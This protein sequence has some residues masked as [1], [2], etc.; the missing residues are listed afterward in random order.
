MVPTPKELIL[1]RSNMPKMKLRS[2]S[3]VLAFAATLV[4]FA[5][6]SSQKAAVQLSATVQVSPPVINLSWTTMASTTSIAI[7][8]KLKTATSWGSIIATP[9]TAALTWTDNTVSVGTAYE[10]K[11]V[12]VAGGV[13]GSGYIASGIEIPVVDY[14]GKMI[15]LVDNMLTGNLVPELDQ[16]ILDLRGDG[17]TVLRS[18]LSPTASVTSVRNTIIGYYNADPANVKAVYIVGNINVPY[19]GNVNPDGHSEHLGAW[20]CDGYYGELN[21]TWTDNTVNSTAAN[22]VENRNVPGDGK[23]DQSNF[24]SDLELQVGRV[25]LSDL[26]AFSNTYT[27]LTRSY[28][29]RAHDFK[30]KAWAPQVRGIMFD[31]LQWI[32]DPLA[33]SG[34]RAMAPLVGPANIT[35]PNQNSTPFHLLVNNNSYMWAYGSG[36]GVA[37]V[38]QGI[39]TFNGAT[40]IATTQDFAVESPGCVFGMSFGSYFG[41]WDN[42]NNFLRAWI[43]RGQALTNVWSAIPGWYM[44]HMGL[45]DNIGYSTWITMNNSS[46]YTPLEDGWQSSIGRTHLGLM[47]D[48]SIRM[49]ML[50]PPSNI[51]ITNSSGIASFAWTAT[52]ETGIAG[53]HVYQFDAGTGAI[54]R[55][56]ATPVSG[57]SY[58][59]PAIP[60]VAGR[61]YMVR[62]V[63]LEVSPSGSYWNQSLGAIGT[64]AGA[65]SND[66][67][68]VPGGSALP[69]TACNDNNACTIND[70]WSAG[71]V[72]V[73]TTIT[74][75]VITNVGGGGTIC[76]GQNISLTVA[77]TGQGT[78]SFAWTGPNGFTSSSQ[79]PTLSSAGTAA[80]GT[81]TV[82]VSNAC[83]SVNQ[84]VPVSVSTAPS[85]TISYA[86]S[87]FCTSASP[88]NVTRTG[89]ANGT[90]TASPSG[91][92]INS[93][94]GAITPGSST[95]GTYTVTYT[96]AAAGGCAQ[97]QTTAS[98]TITAA[99]SAMI[100]Y[101]GSPFCTSASP[102][103]VTRT[104]T[105]NGTYTASP[106]GLSI[107]S[108]SGAIT[109][110]SS[111]AGTY[112]VT[113]TVAAA[114][115]CAQFQTTASVT[116]TAATTWYADTDGD[117]AGD[118]AVSLVACA[119]PGGYVAS[120]GDACPS[121]P[122][123]TNPG[124][125]GCGNPEPGTSCNDG[126]ANTIGDV[127][128]ANCTCAGTPI[129]FD[130]LGVAN[131]TALPGTACNDGNA[132]TG[133][134]T[135]N[136]N[137]QCV[138]Q[139]IDCLG[140]AGG[141]ALPGTACNDNNANTINDVWGNNCTCAGTPVT[142][143]CLGVANGTA[144]PGTAC[145]DNNANTGNDT[146][147]ASC[148][149]V[150]QTMDCLG[151]AGGSALP[152]TA[153]NDNNANTINDV[154][155]NNCTC[156]G[157]LVTFDCLGVA[158]GT[159]LPGTT[160]NDGNATTGND[161]WNANC[162]C[163]G[164]TI[165]CLGVANG[166]ALPGTAC[167][168]N[169]ANTGNDTWNANCQCVGQTFDC[170]G[171]AGGTALPGTACNDN[172]A[173]TIND[174]W[175]N[176]CTCAGTPVTFDCLGVANGTALPGTACNDNNA[177][178]GN[179]TWNANCQ[180]V[181]Q[182]I[183][184]LGV[185][186]GSALPATACNDNNANTI[187]D[188]WGN[189]CTC[190][191]TPVTFDCL[192]VA[193]GTAL[194][195]TACNDNNANTINDVWGNNCT[196]AGTP[197]TFDCLGVA[198]GTALPGTA[199]NDNNATTGN[200]TW[201]A[202]CQCVGQT[203][204]CLGV[205][206]GS[207]LPGS[208]C[209]DNN[210]NTIND[211]WGNNCT[212]AGTPVTFDCLGVAN[213][214]ALPGTACNDGN[215]FT[216]TDQWNP[217]C[218]CVGTLDIADCAGVPGGSATI[219]ACG[220]C[221][222]GTTGLIPDADTDSD[223]LLDC[224]DNCP[225]V[226]NNAQMDY[227]GDGV[228]DACDNCVWQ[229]NPDQ[230]DSD[231]NGQGDVCDVTTGIPEGENEAVFRLSPN[232]SR[233]GSLNVECT[234]AGRRTLRFH[235][236][237]GELVLESGFQQRME[238]D[239]LATGVYIVFAIDAE[240]RP[241]AQTRFVK[242]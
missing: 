30:R 4:S 164:Q 36:G 221:A 204:D 51:A 209:D 66:C 197:V 222:G 233:G 206:G 185:A 13:T 121:D 200:D 116:I 9:S 96:V 39:N 174:V 220:V 216:T 207:A 46:L 82:T 29:N 88:V 99:A 113:Y 168:D 11:V 134:D 230:L 229:F 87:P 183:D 239:A 16:L 223:G 146:W 65:A 74:A 119:Q 199:C 112:T 86:G 201:N 132:N 124:S 192:G 6:T 58:L 137:C 25:D 55:L 194:P 202:N 21:G 100:S 73:G 34:W 71:C 188:V 8:R 153:C 19:S 103:S 196:C 129:I 139:T 79:N 117:G 226:A 38:D 94:S 15:L 237:V 105:A 151:V 83:G 165:D 106:S 189:N 198:N 191:G 162:Q 234:Y 3:I 148:Q 92:S 22:R 14:R 214:T 18:D 101:A 217:D 95:A 125:C 115:G 123:K 5:Q 145:N 205:A 110:G 160:C 107:N 158:N 177:T 33:A 141:T 70:T 181:G 31:N 231:G 142:F 68:G 173:N 7:Y 144:L 195:G 210:A 78:L 28:L 166:T 186:G 20:P 47:G 84:G 122:L 49:K 208:A 159:A 242:Q 75:P 180:C 171:V 240:G 40:N 27:E 203:I 61:D 187:N 143:D 127:I 44:H 155:G 167:N 1:G 35:A 104:G 97:F 238:I 176:N 69:G 42:R 157:T 43:A 241:L 26:P 63:K 175:G 219:D 152:A 156:A 76:A 150:G 228:G 232:P 54:T 48:P 212:C 102:V 67:L 32:S 111:I 60:F 126:N 37:A 24:P 179:D 114:G 2:L 10:Y 172:N 12:R 178:T 118:P 131:G 161:T 163:V 59:N 225:A 81:Y 182:T 170:L 235:N 227:D 147:N 98:V 128:T 236:A 108:S 62:A 41:D 135:W 169:N 109:P 85:A 120:S 133:N 72:C 90:Y 224:N 91:L 184:C 190:A 80:S 149:C 45:G 218:F 77:A 140:V 52:A 138:G 130:C 53:Y 215:P 136:A 211:V 93:S 56:T 213:G 64:S 154:W 17:W 23:F 193:N 57:T 89:T 50:A